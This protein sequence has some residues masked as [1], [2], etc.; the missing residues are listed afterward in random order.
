MYVGSHSQVQLAI[1]VAAAA[2]VAEARVLLALVAVAV[3][4]EEL[5]S[6][7]EVGATA[8]EAIVVFTPAMLV[9][10]ALRLLVVGAES[11]P[12]PHPEKNT[13]VRLLF[14]R[15]TSLED[16]P[17]I[18]KKGS[19]LGT[20]AAFARAT[21]MAARGARAATRILRGREL[22]N[23]VR[24]GERRIEGGWEVGR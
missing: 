23:K 1:D 22:K 21:T 11:H 4:A 6:L 7:T 2:F 13:D 8:V 12:G 24:F 18:Q 15:N 20:G 3:G 19:A 17:K 9:D 10:V 16:S 5:L 14:S